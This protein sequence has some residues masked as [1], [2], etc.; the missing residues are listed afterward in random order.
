MLS[1]NANE[2]LGHVRYKI[3]NAEVKLW[4]FPHFYIEEVFP[5]KFYSQ[6]IE[7]LPAQAEYSK[8]AANYNGRK[9]A[10]PTSTGELSFLESEEFLESNIFA[11]RKQFAARFPD[12]SLHP[13]MDL[14]LILDSQNYAIGPHT[15]APWKLLSLLFYMPK[16]YELEAL[17]TSMY[18]PKDRSFCCPGGPHHKFD[19]FTKVYTA[20]FRPNSCLGFF[21]TDYSFHGVEPITIP[22]RRDVLLWNLYDASMM[23]R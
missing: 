11:F 5:W 2:V 22:C 17:G 4:P 10:D 9:F 3:A 6:F 20:P 7:N 1:F 12:G 13:K 8:G 23:K 15:D 19:N 18:I 14:R 21:K 16:N